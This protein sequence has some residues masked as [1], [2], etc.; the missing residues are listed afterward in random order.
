M[1]KTLWVSKNA[2]PLQP[3]MLR[4][5]FTLFS[6]KFFLKKTRKLKNSDFGIFFQIFKKI[7]FLGSTDGHE[8]KLLA[9]KDFILK[10]HRARAG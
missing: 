5:N 4:V 7:S 2:L 6:K 8:D 3:K 9:L 1:P 10:L